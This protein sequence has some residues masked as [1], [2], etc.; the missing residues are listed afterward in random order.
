MAGKAP[1]SRIVFPGKFLIRR[2]P[3][4]KMTSPCPLQPHSE[5]HRE[6]PKRKPAPQEHPKAAPHKR[7]LSRETYDLHWLDV[8]DGSVAGRRFK[9]HR[10]LERDGIRSAVQPF[11]AEALRD[12]HITRARIAA[13]L[14]TLNHAQ[15]ADFF[16][17]E[18]PRAPK[19][20]KG[21]FGEVVASEHLMQRYGY[22]MPVFKLR[23]RD[24]HLPMR[25]EDIVAFELDRAGS[26]V[27]VVIGEA[28]AVNA[29]RQRTVDDA[30]ARLKSA[31][32]PRPMT[33]SMLS[34]ILYERGD[35]AL[36]EQV[37]RVSIALLKGDFPRSNWIFLIN[38]TQPHD[39]FAVLANESD[40]IGDLCCVSVQL[41]ELNRLVEELFSD[42]P[43]FP[44]EAD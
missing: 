26:I 22:S 1:G 16:A 7:P 18:V 36:A 9:Q 39:P 11:L 34:N 5:V 13:C 33:L 28:K 42:L 12:H 20:R 29:F 27:R 30:H 44:P 4:G 6:M 14:R 15:A 8:A 24:S 40:L 41:P 35:D 17:Q 2:K 38:E 21:N 37:D 32:N 31:F 19:T 10:V 25:G 43:R 23:Y 3:L